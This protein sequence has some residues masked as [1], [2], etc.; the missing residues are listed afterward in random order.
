MLVNMDIIVKPRPRGEPATY[1]LRSVQSA[2]VFRDQYAL[3]AKRAGY[4]V[5]TKNMLVVGVRKDGTSIRLRVIEAEGGSTA[6][7]T[8][9]PPANDRI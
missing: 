7:L 9:K 1:E 6:V 3:N 8:V 2:T 4:Q 5:A